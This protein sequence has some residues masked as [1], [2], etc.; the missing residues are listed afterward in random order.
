M[1]PRHIHS[2]FLREVL[3]PGNSPQSLF[4]LSCVSRSQRSPERLSK[5]PGTYRKGHPWSLTR[6]VPFVS[7]RV[8]PTEPRLFIRLLG[9]PSLEGANTGAAPHPPHL[10]GAMPAASSPAPRQLLLRQQAPGQRQHPGTRPHGLHKASP[11]SG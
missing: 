2:T 8:L 6:A 1:G 4:Q 11:A 9:F 5:L 10:T 7:H 3:Q